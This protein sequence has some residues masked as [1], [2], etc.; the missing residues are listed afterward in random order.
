MKITTDYLKAIKACDGAIVMFNNTPELHSVN[1][2]KPIEIITRDISLFSH[3]SWL[4]HKLKGKLP[5]SKLTFKN[6][7]GYTVEYTYD[8][9][10]KVLTYKNS[11]GFSYEYTYDEKGNELTYKESKGNLYEY[12]YDERRKALIY[13]NFNCNIIADYTQMKYDLTNFEIK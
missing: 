12:T 8:K 9:R 7:S 2:E 6:S 10:G 1:I 4:V 13:K 11:N 3:I 5:V